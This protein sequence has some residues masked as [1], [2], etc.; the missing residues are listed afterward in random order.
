M[1]KHIVFDFDGT[2]VGGTN[3]SCFRCYAEAAAQAGIALPFEVVKERV[4]M[5]WGRSPRI[6]IAGL[7]PEQPGKVDEIL[8]RYESLIDEEILSSVRLLEGAKEALLTLEKRYQLSII[9]GMKQGLLN[10]IVEKFSIRRCFARLISTIDSNISERQKV[11]GYHLALL[12]QE[13]CCKCDEMIC[14]G[15]G[16]SDVAM[17]NAQSVPVVVVLSGV[18]DR[19][20][21]Q[22]LGVK[23]ILQ[24]I[25]ALP[26]WCEGK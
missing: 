24:D 20:A 1:L 16:Q 25:R 8:L 7:V 21:A 19:Q 13:F 17:A 6:E 5:N 12:M 26:E 9:T 22:A 18:L 15:D 14:V 3:E 23:H 4:L 10:R 2:L 11:T